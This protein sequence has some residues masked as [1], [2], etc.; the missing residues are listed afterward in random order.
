MM[1]NILGKCCVSW[2]WTLEPG[3]PPA[4]EVACGR[5]PGGDINAADPTSLQPAAPGSVHM[6]PLNSPRSL[7][8]PLTDEK[9]EAQRHQQL[10]QT[11][12]K[13]FPEGVLTVAQRLMNPTR[14]CEDAGWIPGLP[15]WVKDLALP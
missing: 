1:T 10:C 3:S 14:I 2:R 12:L 6:C 9:N 7:S 5:A 4:V 13:N 11:S 15:Q 8:S